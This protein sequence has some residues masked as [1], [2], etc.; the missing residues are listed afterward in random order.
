MNVL[1][2]NDDGIDS[3][4]LAALCRAVAARG[5]HVTVC[6][7]SGQQSAKAHSFT[8]FEPVMAH[9]R[10]LG[11]RMRPGRWTARRWTASAW[12]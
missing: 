12:G 7:P 9:A 11:V 8:I 2:A 10:Q 1:L 6:A 4:L 5:H 3:R